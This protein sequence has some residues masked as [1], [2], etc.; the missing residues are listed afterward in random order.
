MGD[1]TQGELNF[2]LIEGRTAACSHLLRLSPWQWQIST[3]QV[4][5]WMSS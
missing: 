4:F 3:S 2:N 1:A 5:V